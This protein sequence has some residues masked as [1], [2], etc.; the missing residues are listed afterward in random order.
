MACFIVG[1]PGILFAFVWWKVYRDPPQSGL[2]NDAE[3]QYIEA[4]GAANTKATVRFKWRHVALLLRHRQVL[5]AS[6]G[7]FGGTDPGLL[8]HLVSDLLV[9]HGA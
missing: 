8:P 3:L 1:S 6:I 5:G 4:G 2:V 9:R 7:Q